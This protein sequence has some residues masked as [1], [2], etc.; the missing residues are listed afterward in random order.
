MDK[1][2]W[3]KLYDH[4]TVDVETIKAILEYSTKSKPSVPTP[5]KDPMDAAIEKAVGIMKNGG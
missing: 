3:S 4:K 2:D 1:V 5:P